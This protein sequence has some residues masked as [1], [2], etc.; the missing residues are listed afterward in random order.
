[1]PEVVA[2]GFDDVIGRDADVRRAAVDHPRIDPTTPRT[3]PISRPCASC[4]FG[5]A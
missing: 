2:E 3:A 5:T 1:V 4:A